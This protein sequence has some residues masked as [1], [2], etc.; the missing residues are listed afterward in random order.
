MLCLLV[1]ICKSAGDQRLFDCDFW[2]L[3]FYPEKV[4]VTYSSDSA[5]EV[6]PFM[7]FLTQHGFQAAVSFMND[8][9]VSKQFL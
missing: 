2:R 6:V 9:D 7:D 3:C 8:S 5:I 1:D 4:F